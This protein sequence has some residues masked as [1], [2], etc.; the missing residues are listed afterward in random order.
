MN[1]IFQQM[2]SVERILEYTTLP[3]EANHETKYA[4][5]EEWPS[6]GRIQ[7][8]S[9]SLRYSEKSP[10]ALTSVDVTVEPREKVNNTKSDNHEV[11]QLHVCL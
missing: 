3:Q 2:T 5:P 10:L 8:Q 9:V 6:N 11:F 1:L 4:L 7:M